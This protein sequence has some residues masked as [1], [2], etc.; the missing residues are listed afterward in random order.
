[1][2]KQWD[3]AGEASMKSTGLT[4]FHRHFDA[5]FLNCFKLGVSQPRLYPSS[6]TNHRMQI[7]FGKGAWPRVWQLF[8]WR[9]LQEKADRPRAAKSAAGGISPSIVEVSQ[10]D[11][12]WFSW[13]FCN[14]QD[15]TR[16]VSNSHVSFKAPILWPPDA[17]SWLI[18][19]DHDAGKDWRWKEKG[20]TED[21][22]VGWPHW[23]S[24]DEFG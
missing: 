14:Q 18:G 3:W 22:M 4:W 16:D 5:S 9:Q 6:L 19:K 21:E 23:L 20:M 17:K 2:A 11:S 10:F 12:V 13:W 24:G 1:M 8:R 15:F 7:V